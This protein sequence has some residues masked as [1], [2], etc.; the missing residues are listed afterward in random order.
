MNIMSANCDKIYKYIQYFSQNILIYIENNN[1]Y[2]GSVLYC[3]NLEFKTVFFISIYKSVIN[4]CQ[5]CTNDNK[6]AK[7]IIIKLEEIAKLNNC[8]RLATFCTIGVNGINFKI[9]WIH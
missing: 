7:K 3:I 6:F 5:T 8:T 1:T 4:N 2:I 9:K